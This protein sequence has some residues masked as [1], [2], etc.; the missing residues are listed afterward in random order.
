MQK[1]ALVKNLLKKFVKIPPARRA[2]LGD[3][4]LEK[5]GAR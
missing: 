3:L 4:E 1:R 5:L 2:F